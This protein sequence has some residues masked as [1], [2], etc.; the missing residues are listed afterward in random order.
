MIE[1]WKIA[2]YSSETHPG[3]YRV[4]VKCAAA[5]IEKIKGLFAGKAGQPWKIKDAEFNFS[6]YLNSI[7]DEEAE[8]I[9]KQLEGVKN[10]IDRGEPVAPQKP[11]EVSARPDKP[12]AMDFEVSEIKAESAGKM[13]EDLKNKP[14]NQIKEKTTQ[15][16]SD[17]DSF[18]LNAEAILSP[19]VKEKKAPDE[20]VK[21]VPDET[22]KKTEKKPPA[23]AKKVLP[24]AEKKAPAS[25]KQQAPVTFDV[26][27]A[28][29]IDVLKKKP[30]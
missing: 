11:A 26:F 9:E 27:E 17:T 3:R 23:A 10:K 5:D 18:M 21:K 6:F 15:P 22:V 29:K 7:P 8:L 4:Y 25:Q 19:A 1:K 16:E 30:R 14:S 13:N 20:A 24:P 12:A 28:D 2:K